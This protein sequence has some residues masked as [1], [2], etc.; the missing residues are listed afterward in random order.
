MTV[1]PGIVDVCLA[2]GESQA[3]TG[4]RSGGLALLEFGAPVRLAVSQLEQRGGT[5]LQYV[6]AQM[7]MRHRA[8]LEPFHAM[9]QTLDGLREA[10]NEPVSL[11]TADRFSPVDALVRVSRAPAISAALGSATVPA[12]EPVFV[13]AERR[14]ANSGSR[15]QK[16]SRRGRTP[17]VIMDSLRERI[18]CQVSIGDPSITSESISLSFHF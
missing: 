11:E 1:R 12:M 10:R 7:R 2:A 13:W 5:A 17:E 4:E 3:Q 15:A 6:D 8:G 18:G 14:A 16:P 9:I